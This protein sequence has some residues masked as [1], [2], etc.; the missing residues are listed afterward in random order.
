MA[1]KYSIKNTKFCFSNFIA[2]ETTAKYPNVFLE[3]AVFATTRRQ[4][5]PNLYKHLPFLVSLRVLQNAPLVTAATWAT[6]VF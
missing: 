5:V 4:N 1:G 3:I 6:K 2:S